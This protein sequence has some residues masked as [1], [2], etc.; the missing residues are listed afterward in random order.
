MKAQGGLIMLFV[1]FGDFAFRH[2]A[3]TRRATFSLFPLPMNIR[4]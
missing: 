3:I 1:L 2:R 4:F